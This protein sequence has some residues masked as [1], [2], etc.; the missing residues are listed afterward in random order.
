[1]IAVFV[2]VLTVGAALLFTTAARRESQAH[3]RDT[4]AVSDRSFAP[5]LVA[6]QIRSVEGQPDGDHGRRLP[7][8]FG[9]LG[10]LG[11]AVALA[12]VCAHRG[13]S[14]RVPIPALAQRTTTPR[15]PPRPVQFIR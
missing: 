9:F 11:L 5:P 4:S 15:A 8:S 14:G 13:P 10:L 2:I 12:A 7:S 3:A 6:P 1:M